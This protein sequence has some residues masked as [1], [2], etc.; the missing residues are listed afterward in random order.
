MDLD[1]FVA[2]YRTLMN[3]VYVSDDLYQRIIAVLEQK[4]QEISNQQ[5]D[6]KSD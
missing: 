4:A 6:S 5:Q 1:N 2:W 3:R